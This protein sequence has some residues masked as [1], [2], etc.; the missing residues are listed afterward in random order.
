MVTVERLPV[1]EEHMLLQPVHQVVVEHHELLVGGRVEPQFQSQLAEH[2]LHLAGHG[3]GVARNLKIERPSIVARR[4]QGFKLHAGEPALGQ[5][6]TAAF[7][8]GEE[9]PRSVVVG[10]HH[11][12]SAQCA[13]LGAAD[14]EH[15]AMAAQPGQVDI[16]GGFHAVAQPCPVD[17]QLQAVAGASVGDGRQFGAVVEGSQLRGERQ[18]DHCGLGQVFAALVVDEPFHICAEV[19]RTKLSFVMAEG[20]DFVAACLNGSGLVDADMPGVGGDDGLVTG[21]HGVDDHEVGLRAAREEE[22]LRIVG[23]TCRADELSRMVA[24][25]I[26]TV[27]ERLLTIGAHQGL[28]HLGVGTVVVVAF[29]RNHGFLI[30]V[31]VCAAGKAG[32]LYECKVTLFRRFDEILSK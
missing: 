13:H 4:E 18:I 25:D 31:L 14:V 24:M 15:I 2:G 10:E 17:E 22:H 7:H 30:F 11:G 8:H 19:F 9:M 26:G 3:D 16:V 20:N 6:G 32:G 21:Q 29:K 12:F 5:H 27:G 28:H 23:F 1:G